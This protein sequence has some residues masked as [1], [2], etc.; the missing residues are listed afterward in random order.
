MEKDNFSK[1][2]KNTFL[3]IR[4]IYIESNLKNIILLICLSIVLSVM[5]TFVS[6]NFSFKVLLLYLTQPTL[7]LL[8]TLPLTLVM[9]FVFLLTSRFWISYFVSGSFYLIVQFVNCFKISLRH[10]PFVPADILLGNESTNVIKIS[11]LPIDNSLVIAMV[12]FLIGGISLFLVIEPKPTSWLYKAISIIVT[13]MLSGVLYNAF[14]KNESFYDK[15]K[16]EGTIYSSVDIVRSRG[17]IYSFLVKLNSLKLSP[18]EGY[19]AQEV[20]EVLATYENEQVIQVDNAIGSNNKMPHVIAIMSEAFF[21]ID[22]IP[23]IEFNSSKEP[24]ENYNKIIEEA[25][26]GKIV[27]NVYGGGTACTECEFLTGTCLSISNWSADT[28]SA[29]IRKDTFSLARLFANKGYKTTALHPGYQWF[30]NRFNVYEYFGFDERYF[31]VDVTE[32]NTKTLTGYVSDMDTYKFLLKDFRNHLERDPINPYFNFT[33]TIENHGPYPNEPIGYPEILKQND[34]VDEQYYNLINNY[35]GGLKQNDEAL[36]YLVEQLRKSEE[37]VVLVYFGDHLPFLGSEFAG[38]KA[39]NYSV[40]AYVG[41]DEYLN[42]YE[43]PYFIWSNDSARHLFERQGKS[44]LLGEAPKI[45]SNY[46][47]TVFLDYMGINDS[48]YFNCLKDIKS[49]LPVITSRFYKNSNGD[50]TET[51]KEDERALL[52]KYTNL[53]YYML[54]ENQIDSK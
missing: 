21:D 26:H 32:R 40:G 38:Y 8:N 49:Q 41:V 16:V 23:G 36:G 9:L 28:Y 25:Y 33:V 22:R 4:K 6:S 34:S 10:E 51:L 46:L 54:F 19:L 17:F 50:F 43:T 52:S 29:Y 14:Y 48:A 31:A 3:H 37:P 1:L 7:F 44:V 47:S 2:N 45:S 13:V 39:M 18:P 27:T 20:K 42:T 15:F 30:Y 24:L 11:E 35:V 53:Q 12:L 5:G